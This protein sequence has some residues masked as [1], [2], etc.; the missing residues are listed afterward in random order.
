MNIII[1]N[2]HPIQYFSPLYKELNKDSKTRVLVLYGSDHGI[3]ESFDKQFNTTFKYDVNLTDGFNYKVLKNWRKGKNHFNGFLGLMN[4]EVIN[5]LRREPKSLLI[6]HGW[7][8]LTC[9]LFAIAGRFLGHKVCLRA[10]TPM[11]HF[12][13]KNEVNK[14][15]KNI[16]LG[17][18]YFKLFDYFL[19][20]GEGNKRFYKYF[21]I[22]ES[23]LIFT[24]YSVNNAD[25][26]KTKISDSKKIDALK[27]KLHLPKDKL[28]LPL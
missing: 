12:Q 26:I 21:N 11:K 22:P 1:F 13:T 19:F 15:F 14:A 8:F 25:F 24:P 7:A 6:V 23:K 10:E 3:K 5:I 20:I 17:K 28:I 9:W 2:T 4:F 27:E 16:F 18:L